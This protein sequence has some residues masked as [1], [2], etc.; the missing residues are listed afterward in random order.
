MYGLKKHL[1]ET[2]VIVTGA[3]AGIGA[4]VVRA[5]AKQ[6]AHVVCVARREERLTA[7]AA[8]LQA[9]PGERMVMAGDV[10]DS[11][12][13]TQL[14]EAVLARFGRIDVLINN[15]GMG[16]SSLL[17]DVPVSDLDRMTR[18]NLYAPLQLVQ[19]ALPTMLAQESGHIINVS[20]IVSVRP[21]PKLAYYTATKAAVDHITRGLRMELRRTPIVVTNLYPGRTRTEFHQ[22]KLGTSDTRKRFGVSADKVAAC[23]VRAIHKQ[24]K[25]VYITLFDRVFVAFNRH[26]PRM[27]DVV[28]GRLLAR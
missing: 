2:V 3:S 9:L 17:R 1:E 6:G 25:E 12:F 15:A 13:I 22:A 10:T 19:A 18:L 24:H 5:L 8:E 20:S 23:V 21:L 4:A 26:F 16:H 7:L 11:L 28:F 14:I 27:L